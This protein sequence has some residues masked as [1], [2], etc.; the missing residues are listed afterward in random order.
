ML[1]PLKWLSCFSGSAFLRLKIDSRPAG[2]HYK[3]DIP[4]SDRKLSYSY[5]AFPAK[6]FCDIV[7]EGLDFVKLYKMNHD[8]QPYALA[9]Y[10]VEQSGKRFAGGYHR[11][12]IVEG[13]T[14]TFAFDPVH[15]HPKDPKWHEFLDA[16]HCWQRS[17]GGIPSIT[18]S[19]RVEHQDLRWGSEAICGEPSP[20]FTTNYIQ[21]F[22]DAK[23]DTTT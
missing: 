3:T 1:S 17:K 6:S 16:F 7:S 11:K 13:D 23:K 14:H 8:F 22:F 2:F 19:F 5:C 18:Q 4:D 10:F 12:K 21:Q 9:V 15:Y 20:R